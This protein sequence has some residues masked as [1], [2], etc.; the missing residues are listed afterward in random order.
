ME[1]TDLYKTLKEHNSSYLGAKISKI[2]Q[3]DYEA[4]R[5]QKLLNKEKGSADGS[6]TGRKKLKEPSLLKVLMKCFG[7][8]LIFYGVIYA[9]SDI[10]FRYI[11]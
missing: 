7:V 4:Y 1:V 6:Y 10:V 5:K 3:K 2:W 11:V 8:Q 9:I